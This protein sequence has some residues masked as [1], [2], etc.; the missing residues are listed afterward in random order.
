MDVSA[1][2]AGGRAEAPASWRIDPFAITDFGRTPHQMESLFC[3]VPAVAGKKA[4][5][6]AGKI[7]DF[8]G[9]CGHGGGPFD[10]IRA[11][12]ASGTLDENLRRVRLGKY[13]LLARCYATAAADGDLDLRAAEPGR[14]ERIPG[15]GMKSSR[16]F[17]LHSRPGA[18]VGVIDTHLLKFLR[19]IGTER[20]P[21][22]VPT[23]RDYTRLEAAVLAEADR[24]GLDPA[25]FD[26]RVWSWYS[27]GNRAAPAFGAPE[28]A[29]APGT[30]AA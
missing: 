19:A 1:D 16:F 28:G 12:T 8:L 10:R 5:V 23:G 6:I 17:V 18:R 30:G 13:G 25:D 4:T 3:F 24:L 26:L 15:F 20:V 22:T 14:L 27:S 2:E 21:D 9:G 11:M 7:Q 29:L